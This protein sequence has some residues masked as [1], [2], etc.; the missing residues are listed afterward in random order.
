MISLCRKES[1]GTCCGLNKAY[2]K[3][4]ELLASTIRSYIG[5]FPFLQYRQAISGSGIY[6]TCK[7][8]LDSDKPEGMYC[9]N[10]HF[11]CRDECFAYYVHSLVETPHRLRALKGQVS[12]PVENC[13]APHWTTEQVLKGLEGSRASV[14]GIH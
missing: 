13:S 1:S 2:T 6:E 4:P 8:C 3:L 5:K 14:L 12:C 9:A 11:V 7:L 10:K